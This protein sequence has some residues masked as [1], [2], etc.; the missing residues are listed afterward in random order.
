MTS[1]IADQERRGKSNL[2]RLVPNGPLKIIIAGR[3]QTNKLGHASGQRYEENE[4]QDTL[5]PSDEQEHSSAAVRLFR[6]FADVS[7]ARS[8][9]NYNVGEREAPVKL[10]LLQAVCL[11]ARTM[12]LIGFIQLIGYCP[13]VWNTC[14]EKR[15][16]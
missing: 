8:G 1:K 4:E 2:N 5:T 9:G 15:E 6:R 13:L 12:R 7:L 16:T 3:N 11:F 10:N 14:Q